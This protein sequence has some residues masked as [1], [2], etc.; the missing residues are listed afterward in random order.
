M[1]GGKAP[2]KCLICGNKHMVKD[3]NDH[4]HEHVKYQPQKCN[5]CD[6]ASIHH[7]DLMDH[8][9]ET[10]HSGSQQKDPYKAWLVASITE[11]ILYAAKH[12]TEELCKKK[13]ITF[14]PPTPTSSLVSRSP[15]LRK[16]PPVTPVTVR[17]PVS[18]DTRV[19]REVDESSS[20]DDEPP[21]PKAAKKAVADVARRRSEN[22][23][24]QEGRQREDSRGEG[25]SDD[26]YK[27]KYQ[28]ITDMRKAN[29]RYTKCSLCLEMVLFGLDKRLAHMRDQHMDDV[30][31][32][33]GYDTRLE[34][35]TKDAF[36]AL[37]WNLRQCSACKTL[38]KDYEIGSSSGR[39][40][41]VYNSHCKTPLP[42]PKR[43]CAYG[44][45][46][47]HAFAKHFNEAHA[48]P[49]WKTLL[50]EMEFHTDFANHKNKL[51]TISKLIFTV[52]F[53]EKQGMKSAKS[54][55]KPSENDD[56]REDW[57]QL[58]AL[59]AAPPTRPA[60]RQLSSS[61][62]RTRGSPTSD[63]D[64]SDD[65]RPASSK[66]K[67]KEK[68]VRRDKNGAIRLETDDEE[69]EEESET[70]R[71]SKEDKEEDQMEVDDKEEAK[72]G[73]GSSVSSSVATAGG[74]SRREDNKREPTSEVKTEEEI[75]E[76]PVTP[77]TR[78]R[79]VLLPNPSGSGFSGRLLPSEGV[80][81]IV[82]SSEEAAAL[83]RE[84]RWRQNGRGRGGGGG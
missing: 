27:V 40:S 43:G 37:V 46:N 57:E 22:R 67:E 11:D 56:E 3:I 35:R 15:P 70:E 5:D 60:P 38:G 21:P 53:P 71:E 47:P 18:I 41:H 25:G 1:S 50:P 14:L 65:E 76:E 83:R 81:N 72:S 19:R 8:T 39:I 24:E 74:N 33:K 59:R 29:Q 69:E 75:K 17:P 44:N 84:A 79:P 16:Q 7:N 12:G 20:E 6:F 51:D 28:E 77:S 2:V 64:D 61:A 9:Y 73:G 55:R 31:E 26:K 80:R 30:P 23:P 54:K 13:G 66:K 78:P 49:H 58:H 82:P 63:E 34:T 68:I 4:V 62:K 45:A 10:D 32:G 42:C 36:P 52:E 48:T